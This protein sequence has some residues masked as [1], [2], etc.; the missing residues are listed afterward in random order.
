M[1]LHHIRTA[2]SC[3]SAALLAASLVLASCALPAPPTAPQGSN[4][5]AGAPAGRAAVTVRPQPRPSAAQANAP[6]A[7]PARDPGPHVASANKAVPAARPTTPVADPARN[8][9]R[10]QRAAAA[11]AGPAPQSCIAPDVVQESLPL[12]PA[13]D[14]EALQQLLAN[15]AALAA[16]RGQW[17]AEVRLVKT[18]S[19]TR[20]MKAPGFGC[21]NPG[22]GNVLQT[23]GRSD[24]QA[25]NADIDCIAE[26]KGNAGGITSAF[27]PPAELN[28]RDAITA[29]V[30]RLKAQDSDL[31]LRE[32]ALALSLAQLLKRAASHWQQSPAPSWALSDLV[33]METLRNQLVQQC[34]TQHARA[35]AA[36][37]ALAQQATSALPAI[38]DA[39]LPLQADK[40]T[41]ALAAA[42]TGSALRGEMKLLFPTPVLD[43]RARMQPWLASALQK[44]QARVAVID[45]R[46]KREQEA[47][48]AELARIAREQ[49]PEFLARKRHR[50]NAAANTAPTSDE[51]QAL[52]IDYLIADREDKVDE[53]DRK[54]NRLSV[55][56]TLPGITTIQ[57]YLAEI[58]LS[59]LSCKPKDRKQ[60]CELEYTERKVGGLNTHHE[61]TGPI[62]RKHGAEFSWSEQDGLQSPGL[63][64]AI[65]QAHKDWHARVDA[66][67]ER[68]QA[69]R[70]AMDPCPGGMPH[71]PTE[72]DRRRCAGR[73]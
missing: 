38:F 26:A 11:L 7:P 55:R 6:V 8:G 73:F 58:N 67:I 49:S 25:L 20:R 45:A 52:V 18:D 65:A 24:E 15:G 10:Y 36:S 19:T 40:V 29:S 48:S 42:G 35:T 61:P 71:A 68:Q 47:Q 32:K 56:V 62:N 12:L 51:V 39:V 63:K 23:P 27:I 21:M 41:T 44:E 17:R 5:S 46:I 14:H 54:G 22:L 43:Q 9:P 60:F 31:S 66:A 70:R 50:Q 16:E 33:G 13:A 57:A 2:W 4:D 30:N 69:I 72:S 34:T 59:S 28:A 37:D 1:N 3:G 53:F 64:T